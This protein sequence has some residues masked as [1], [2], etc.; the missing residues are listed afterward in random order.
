[1]R[2]LV[3][4]TRARIDLRVVV[5][6]KCD[7]SDEWRSSRRNLDIFV[8]RYMTD[9]HERN[10]RISRAGAFGVSIEIDRRAQPV[11]KGRA[12]RDARAICRPRAPQRRRPRSTSARAFHADGHLDG[13]RPRHRGAARRPARGRA[14]PQGAPRLRLV[15]FSSRRGVAIVG[16]HHPN[17]GVCPD[18]ARALAPIRSSRARD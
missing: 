10:M 13:R 2:A 7:I 8:Y 6:G 16:T 12:A 18:R 17:P 5:V 15:I 14:P 11:G 4:W 1:M 3:V 9:T